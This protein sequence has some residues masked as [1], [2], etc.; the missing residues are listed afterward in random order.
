MRPI[1]ISI[2]GLRSYR[3]DCTINFEKRS[4]VAIVGDTG[5]GK[6]SILEAI[7]YALYNTCTWRADS[8]A[9]IAD[10]MHTM[11]VVLDFDGAGHRWR[12]TRS[13]SR[14]ASPRPVHKLECLSDGSFIALDRETQVN[15]KIENIVGLDRRTFLIAVLL[16]QGNFQSLLT[17]E[18]PGERAKILKGI[19][20][21][22]E[23]E[24]A[25]TCR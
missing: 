23:L 14:T 6:S 1:Q 5:S 9:L 10:G 25:K 15:A 20:R 13:T 24:E 4:L 11:L 22:T 2:R 19:F 21:V 7:T 16:P 18:A 3:K 17:E 12:I 8:K